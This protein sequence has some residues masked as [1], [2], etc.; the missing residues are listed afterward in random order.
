MNSSKYRLAEFLLILFFAAVCAI[1]AF[2]YVSGWY[3]RHFVE[4]TQTDTPVYPAIV[5]EAEGK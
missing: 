5:K 3:P 2:L 1:D 4:P